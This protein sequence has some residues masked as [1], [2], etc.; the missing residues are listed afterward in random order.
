MNC[1]ALILVFLNSAVWSAETTKED[2]ASAEAKSQ[3]AP[4][5]KTKSPLIGPHRHETGF[6]ITI[7]NPDAGA[8]G[9]K[10]TLSPRKKR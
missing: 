9:K 1:L 6:S 10:D 4:S 5:R 7:N 3:K 2:I 8:T